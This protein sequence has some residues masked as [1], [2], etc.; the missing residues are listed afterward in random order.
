MITWL[1]AARVLVHTRY[2]CA[3]CCLNA[4][5]IHFNTKEQSRSALP[6][7]HATCYTNTLHCLLGA[8][9]PGPTLAPALSNTRCRSP[10]AP[11]AG[12]SCVF[13]RV[14]G[15]AVVYCAHK[16]MCACSSK[17]RGGRVMIVVDEFIIKDMAPSALSPLLSHCIVTNRPHEAWQPGRPHR[18]HIL[19]GPSLWLS[20][21]FSFSYN[22]QVSSCITSVIIAIKTWWDW[23]EGDSKGLHLVV[24]EITVSSTFIFLM[25]QKLLNQMLYAALRDECNECVG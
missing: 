10:S 6:F 12:G 19:V 7:T 24:K 11:G 15:E 13:V 1:L 20:L 23:L 18:G 5:G 8:G 16:R 17:R 2:T 22:L 3:Q 4:G 25:W 9:W 21:L 14:S